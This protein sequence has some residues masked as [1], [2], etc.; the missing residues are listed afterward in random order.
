MS[1][2]LPFEVLLSESP[3]D[4]TA[5]A[6]SLCEVATEAPD[7]LYGS[8]GRLTDA[9]DDEHEPVRRA[10][11][12]A[13]FEIGVAEPEAVGPVAEALV[14]TLTDESTAVRM[15][16]ARPIAAL[17]A[18]RPQRLR[19]AVAQL[20]PSLTDTERV[21][22]DVAR[23]LASLA[24]RYPEA[25][26]EHVDALTRSLLDDYHPVQQSV[27]RAFVPLER[28]YP[29]LLDVVSQ[30]LQ[31]LA[32]SDVAAV[33]QAACRA[34]AANDPPWARRVL[35]ERCRVDA[36]PVV[37][38][39]A[40]AA[41]TM[42]EAAGPKPTDSDTSTADGVF[43]SVTL[44]TWVVVRTERDDEPTFLAGVVTAITHAV[45]E[46]DEA[47]TAARTLRREDFE[48]REAWLAAPR[49]EPSGERTAVHL[50][51]PFRNYGVNLV[52]VPDGVGVEYTSPDR[53]M[54]S[55]HLPEDVWACSADRAHLLAADP[56]DALAFE[57]EGATHEITVTT[58]G[59]SDGTYRVTGENRERGYAITFRPLGTTPMMAVFEKGRAFRAK[60]V[61]LTAAD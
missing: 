38:E 43:A 41:L 18:A 23:A 11:A 28:T 35:R 47:A 50:H 9:L 46:A 26:H 14:E 12:N 60:N 10:I 6:Q 48:S 55:L 36:D 53:E 27:L 61:Q 39:T 52:P 2:S 54:P 7:R 3:E 25:L 37:R 16:V 57:L 30:R 44:D 21:R 17:A 4:R 59:E 19:F 42:V 49:I 31:D 33:R 56:G 32:T 29:G 58:A 34:I 15:G 5:A 51:N 24:A 1:Q 45:S 13:L 20:V 8:L 40:R 22:G